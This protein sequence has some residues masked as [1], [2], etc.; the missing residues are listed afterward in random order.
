M[1]PIQQLGHVQQHAQAT[2]GTEPANGLL[3]ELSKFAGKALA[4]KL[5]EWLLTRQVAT[6]APASAMVSG[7]TM[8]KWAK[9]LLKSHRGEIVTLFAN[10]IEEIVDLLLALVDE[11][12][13]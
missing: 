1:E 6:P 7:Q 12:D 10:N 2:F 9:G 3:T 4:K 8:W 5:L 13:E 11:D